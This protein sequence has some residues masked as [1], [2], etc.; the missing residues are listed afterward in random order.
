MYKHLKLNEETKSLIKSSLNIE[1]NILNLGLN[2]WKNKLNELKKEHKISTEKF[3][4]KFNKGEL[5][6]D[7]KW[8]EWMFAY[9]AYNHVKEKLNLVKG[10]TYDL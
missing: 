10:I 8:F 3:V 5:G 9:K 4:S 7:K 6:D 1:E 2:K